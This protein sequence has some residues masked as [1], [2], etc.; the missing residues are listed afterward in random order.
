MIEAGLVSNATTVA[1]VDIGD[2]AFAAK[3]R[4]QMAAIESLIMT[5]LAEADPLLFDCMRHLFSAGECGRFRPLFTVLSAETGPDPGN[6]EVILAGAV[7]EL[8]HLATLHHNDVMDDAQKRRGIPRTN[9]RWENN[10]AILAGDYV[11]ATASR[12]VSRLGPTAVRIV[13]ETFADLVTGQMRETAG[14]PEGGDE[15][16]HYLKVIGEKNGSLIAATGRLGAMMSGCKDAQIERVSRPG[17][18]V[19]I[20]FQISDDIIDIE[21]RTDESGKTPGTHLREGVHS[22]PVL[23]A[24]RD[25]GRGGDRLRVLLAAPITDDGEVEEARALLCAS[26]GLAKAKAVVVDYVDQAKAELAELPPGAAGEALRKLTEYTVQ[27]R[28]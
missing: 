23:Y 15:T 28:R 22:L 17:G 11:L 6:D 19:G 13:A 10:I 8:I 25:P 9:V 21:R 4:D 20:A 16:A 5:E 18:I 7:C 24:L 2:P 26:G 12:L 14:V 3:V 27:R 1:G